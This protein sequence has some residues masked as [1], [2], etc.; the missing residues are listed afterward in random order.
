[1]SLKNIKELQAQRGFTIVELLIVIVVIGILAAIVIVA[2]NGI[3]NQAKAQSSKASASNIQKKIEA[4]NASTT[5]YPTDTTYANFTTTLN[6]NSVS[7]LQGT[8]LVLGTP[9]DTTT[10]RAGIFRCTATGTG[11]S[12]TWYDYAAGSAVTAA[13]GLKINYSGSCGTWTELT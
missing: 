11:F 2:Y 5:G 4:Y 1:M 13:N 6:S 10:N 9:N 7:T 8:N 12:V 3:Q